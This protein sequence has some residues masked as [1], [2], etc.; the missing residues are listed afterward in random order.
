MESKIIV[1]ATGERSTEA[2]LAAE[3]LRRAAQSIGQTIPIEMRSDRGCLGEFSADQIGAA[4]IVLVV[5]DGDPLV[6]RF[7]HAN[8]VKMS[9]QAVFNNPAEAIQQLSLT[10]TTDPSSQRTHHDSLIVAVTSCP[11]GIAHT[12]MA[13]EGL[14]QAA[15]AL[16]QRIRVET[17]GS[18]GAQDTL[19][20]DE[21]VQADI[22]LIAA[23]REVDLARFVGK[24]LYKTG[25]KPAINDG[26]KLIRTALAEAK[27]YG[28]S[29]ATPTSAG[30]SFATTPL[31]RA[32]KH[33]MNG[34]SFMLPFI[35]A[36]GMLIAISFALG[37]V[38]APSAGSSQ[39]LSQHLLALGQAGAT[40]IVPI[41]AAYI[42]HSI[43]D[44]PGLVS[45]MI[46]GVLAVQLNAGFLGGIAAGFLAG[47]VTLAI[48]TYL[49]LPNKLAGM[50][51]I[52]ILPL[53]GTLIVGLVMHYLAGPPIAWLMETLTD[54]LRQ[55]QSGSALLLG[56]LLGG[57][58]A[59]DMGGPINK[60]AYAFSAGLL[61]SHIY[62]PMAAVMVAGMT[63]PL[64]AALATWI[65]PNRFTSEEVAM[66]PSTVVLGLIFVSEGAIPYGSRDPLKT[67]PAFILGSS[68][69]GAISL[70]NGVTLPV[71][72]G[73]IFAFP[74]VNHI[75]WYSAALLAGSVVT[76]IA[77]GLFKKSTIL[78]L[79]SATTAVKANSA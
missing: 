10:T 67:I 7:A 65:F 29:V 1:I 76:A 62:T 6:E 48:N 58:M 34:I 21:I 11:T 18:V 78:Q 75:A 79:T 59:V 24:R 55:L 70:T 25:T 44:R 53:L 33:L 9:L 40:L 13:A 72:H 69:A 30:P 22:V 63:P 64:G 47:Y 74:T 16:G 15:A 3:A 66:A 46:G 38:T 23:D 12:F 14:Q 4:Q 50:K 36:S 8:I 57:M 77:L 41:L 39:S 28:Q 54:S 27:L 51:P 37:G 32:Y 19:T 60:A 61:A 35:T 31:S 2:V 20:A 52:L 17:Q 42:A 5:G 49:P 26:E 45:G 56:L 68:I 73:G 71:P 43:A